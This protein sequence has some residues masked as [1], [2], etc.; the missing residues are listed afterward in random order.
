MGYCYLGEEDVE[1][2]LVAAGKVVVEVEVEN[3]QEW[4]SGKKWVVPSQFQLTRKKVCA[5]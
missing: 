4:T 1:G 2:T 5:C 3:M